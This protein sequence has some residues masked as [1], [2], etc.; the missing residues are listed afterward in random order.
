MIVRI[1]L[2][3][4][5]GLALLAC[6]DSSDT[7]GRPDFDFSTADQWMDD[8]VRD[9]D[10]FDGAG[11]I[12]VHRDYGIL[13][14]AAFGTHSEELVYLLAS[15]SKIPSVTLLMALASDPDLAFDIDVPVEN[16][17]S[18]QGVYP[19]V[20]TAQM[21]SNTSGIPGLLTGLTGG[22]GAHGCQYAAAGQ[23]PNAENLQTCGQVI[24]ETP[25]EGTLPPGTLFDYG[26]SQWQL[27]GAVAEVVGGD[28][29]ANLFSRYIAGPCGLEVYEFGNMLGDT[30]AWTGFPDSL[31]GRENP[32]IEGGA[33][34]NLRDVALLLQLHLNDGRCGRTQVISEALAQRMRVDVGTAVGAREWIGSSGRGYGMGWWIPEEGDNPTVF[35]D[36]GA[37]GSVTWIDTARNYGVFVALA[38]YDDIVAARRGPARINPELPPIMNAIF[39]NPVQGGL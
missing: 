22:Y 31:V 28:S 15:V 17:L 19:G 20:T 30:S 16:Y 39:D 9:E 21:L 38:K 3:L 25:L 33:I 2:G 24:Y 36:G 35:F 1:L 8:F 10:L 14:T 34:S 12:V 27:A 18:W 5:A 32:N 29:W 37:Y 11:L 7:P 26:G 13:H 23:F 6:S 4:C